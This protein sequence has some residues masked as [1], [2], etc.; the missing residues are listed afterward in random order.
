MMPVLT[1]FIIETDGA[2]YVGTLDCKSTSEVLVFSFFQH[3][4]LECLRYAKPTSRLCRK[5]GEENTHKK[6]LTFWWERDDEPVS[7]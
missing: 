2:V 7:K 6:V 3:V 4:F 1:L 5:S